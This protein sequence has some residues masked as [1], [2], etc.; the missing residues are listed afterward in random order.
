[1]GGRHVKPAVQ[2]WILGTNSAFAL[3]SGKTTENL[4]RVG[5]SQDLPDA[6]WLLASSPG[7]NTRTLT[8]SASLSEWIILRPTASLSWYQSPIWGLWPDFNYCQTLADLLIL[9]GS[10]FYNCCCLLQRSHSQVRVPRGSWPH[11]TVSDWDSTTWRTRPLYL[12]LPGTGWPGYI[13]R[14]W[15]WPASLTDCFL[16]YIGRLPTV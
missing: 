4:D 11:F 6:N 1:V 9:G 12:Y 10:V 14:L 8:N 7:L 5:R 3:G 15:V 13:P 2:S 16:P